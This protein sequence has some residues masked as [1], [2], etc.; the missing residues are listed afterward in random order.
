MSP[1]ISGAISANNNVDIVVVKSEKLQHGM[2][3][4]IFG[5]LKNE[6]VIVDDMTSTGGTIIKAVNKIRAHGGVVRYCCVCAQR[7]SVANDSLREI[8]VNL[9][10]IAT[11]S[12]I[13]VA[14]EQQF[15]EKELMI[16]KNENIHTT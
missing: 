13:L 1:I 12:E 15:S 3:N 10:A 2:K 16:L 9:I 5:S 14:L 6:I 8:G 7:D 4:D 11:F